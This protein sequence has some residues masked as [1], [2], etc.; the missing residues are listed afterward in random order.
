[1]LVLPQ[2]PQLVEIVPK[3]RVDS[4]E[5][6]PWADRV[7]GQNITVRICEPRMHQ[8]PHILARANNALRKQKT[9]SEIFIVSPA[10]AS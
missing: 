4:G 3:R 2:R 10:F 8:A 7:T 9:G 6:F 1:M 5:N